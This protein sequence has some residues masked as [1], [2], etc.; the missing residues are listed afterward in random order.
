MKQKAKRSTTK[1]KEGISIFINPFNSKK[2][3]EYWFSFYTKN[4]DN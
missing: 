2:N 4:L 3:F 1:I